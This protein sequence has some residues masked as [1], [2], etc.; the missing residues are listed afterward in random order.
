M[1][2]DD[3]FMRSY[4]NDYEAQHKKEILQSQEERE[5]A[6]RKRKKL[7][8]IKL[9][10]QKFVDLEVIVKHCHHYTK[11][12]AT[13][14]NI[15]P[16]PFEYYEKD[17]SN[18]WAPGI[19]ILFNHPAEVEIAIPNHIE[20]E[21][22]VVIRA[23]THHPDAYV[24][25]QKFSTFEAACEALGEFLRRCTVSMK[26]PREY[27]EDI[28]QKIKPVTKEQHTSFIHNVPEEPPEDIHMSSKDSV[29]S[30]S[31]KN[32]SLKKISNLFNRKNKDE[33]D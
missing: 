6:E 24:L 4:L 1:D 17:S 20:D 18:L 2:L 31:G 21:G 8:I 27:L 25:E 10:L 3:I 12:T 30:T 7:E 14:A 16:Q 15:E 29:K 23:S 32:L 26:D 9:F 22:V 28:Q 13:L 19:S 5:I 33:D 11:N